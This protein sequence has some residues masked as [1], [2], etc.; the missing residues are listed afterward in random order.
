MDISVIICTYNRCESLRRTLQS[1]CDL[2]IPEG[3][4]WEVI[5]G[6]NNSTDAT[7]QI[8]EEFS[9]KLPLRYIFEPRQ[10]KSYALNR[11]MREATGDLRLFTDDDASLDQRWLAELHKAASIHQ[12]LTFFGGK[13]FSK[14]EQPPP[15][16]IAENLT[17]LRAYPRLEHG[18]SEKLLQ[19]DQEEYVIGANIAFRREVYAAGHAYR[20]EIGPSGSDHSQTGRTGQEEVDFQERLF[21]AGYRGLY[22]PTAIVFHHDPPYRMTGRYIRKYYKCMGRSDALCLALP[23]LTHSWFRV[24]RY[25]WKKFAIACLRYGISRPFGPSRIWLKAECNLFYLLGYIPAFRNRNHPK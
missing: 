6:D 22:V 10:G 15:A 3:V 23:D 18:E 12:D 9:G 24:P 25:T 4:T 5:V 16:W 14:W 8:C 13:V 2:V 19:T 20:T 1:C 11:C 21:R 7:K 17:W